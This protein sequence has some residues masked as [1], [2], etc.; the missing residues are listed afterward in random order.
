MDRSCKGPKVKSMG[1]W[2]CAEEDPSS[3][4]RWRLRN[5][6]T[7]CTGCT[8]LGNPKLDLGGSMVAVSNCDA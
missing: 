6:S 1:T 2:L 3:L 8:V 4:C 7:H 5:V